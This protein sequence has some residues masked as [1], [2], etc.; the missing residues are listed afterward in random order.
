MNKRERILTAINGGMP[1]RVPVFDF[2]EGKRIFKEVLGR[3]IN[4][5]SAKDITECSIKLGFDAIVVEYGGFFNMEE[6]VGIG[7][8]YTDEWGVTYKNTGVSWPLDSPIGHP[9]NDLKDLELWL[10]KIPDPNLP[11]RLDNVKDAFEISNNEVAIIGGVIGPLTHSI[12]IL[13]F[14]GLMTK[15]LYEP[16]FVEEVFK[17]SRDYYSIAIDKLIE[18][19]VD[20]IL[21]ADDLGFNLGLFASPE[22]YIKHFFPYLFDL[23]DKS[24]KNDIPVMLH[25]D[26]NLNVILDDLVSAGISALHPIE[27][28]SNMDIEKIR[29]RYGKKLCLIGNINASTTLVNGPIDKIINEVKHTINIAGRDGAYILASDS[30]YHDGIPPKNFIAMIEAAKKYGKYPIEL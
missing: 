10:K 22:L 2:L 1:D 25:A 9:V 6:G 13:G 26:G 17:I 3:K 12:L 21:V 15:I 7:E 16:D 30:D 20:V 19:G 8:T 5:P 28:K 29:K 11:S 24:K 27:R 18:S 14:E 23:F 4:S